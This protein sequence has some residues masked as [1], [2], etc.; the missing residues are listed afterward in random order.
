[1]PDVW[2]VCL[3]LI[4]FLNGTHVF[5]IL[6][7]NSLLF[8][9]VI[10]IVNDPISSTDYKK[11]EDPKIYQ[12]SKTGR[13]PLTENWLKESSKACKDSKSGSKDIMTAYKLCRVEF[14]YWGMQNKI[15]KFI[16]DIG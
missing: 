6:K 9:D 3:A 10:D 2:N 1:M 15:E 12:S 13:G 5:D 16:H 4:L 11:E 14:R 8:S 7:T